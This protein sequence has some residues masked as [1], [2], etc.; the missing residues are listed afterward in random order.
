MNTLRPLLRQRISPWTSISKIGVL[1]QGRAHHAAAAALSLLIGRRQDDRVVLVSRPQ[2]RSLSTTNKD[3]YYYDSQS[4]KH[5]PVHD[6]S[7][8][9]LFL[10]VDDAV[11]TVT[12]SLMTSSVQEGFA[13][14]VLHDPNHDIA[15]ATFMESLLT[16]LQHPQNANLPKTFQVWV[17]AATLVKE[18]KDDKLA[19]QLQQQHF[20]YRV[21][22][23][24]PDDKGSAPEEMVARLLVEQQLWSAIVC[25]VT[26][27]SGGTKTDPLQLASRVA[28]VVDATGGSGGDY[29]YLRGTDADDMVRLA[30]ELAYLDVEGPTLKARMVIDVSQLP[31]QQD[32]AEVLDE[33]LLA[34]INKYVV[35]QSRV[36][37]VL[38]MI[39][40]QGK[41]CNV[42]V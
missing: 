35:D 28:S 22:V 9:S 33:C 30:E 32:M 38:D 29:V 14:I 3:N 15:S 11:E 25:D 10:P 41:T 34:G 5:V 18:T 2:Q 36:A 23:G 1:P 6:E 8:V 20:V 37:S 26:T 24:N 39:K 21:N 4:G 40:E 42:Q 7:H 17:D 27:R 19:K 16:A 12:P 13:G 31:T